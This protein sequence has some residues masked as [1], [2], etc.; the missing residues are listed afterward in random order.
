[1]TI[2]PSAQTPPRCTDSALAPD[3]LVWYRPG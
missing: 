3:D 2:V 1:M